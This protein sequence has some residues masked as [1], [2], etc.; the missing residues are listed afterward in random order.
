MRIFARK[1]KKIK[2]PWLFLATC[3]DVFIDPFAALAK[4]VFLKIRALAWTNP[5]L[6]SKVLKQAAL[7]QRSAKQ[8]TNG[9][10]SV[11]GFVA[12]SLGWE[13]NSDEPFYI[14]KPQQGTGF[15]I[16]EGSKS[17]LIE[18]L[19][20]A[21]RKFL[22]DHVPERQDYFGEL[23]SIDIFLTRFLHDSSFSTREDMEFL[24]PFLP[25]F[26]KDIQRV[27]AILQKLWSGQVYSAV[28]CKAAGLTESDCCFA[29]NEREDH[30]HLFKSCSFYGSTRPIG[31]F[32]D[33][34]WCT[35]IFPRSPIFDDWVREQNV[36]PVL[37]SQW[38]SVSTSEPVFIDGSAFANKWQPLR[39]AASAFWSNTHEWNSVLPGCDQTSQRAETY[40]LLYCVTFFGGDLTVY[41][42]CMN[43]LTG[44]HRL[45]SC[46]FSPSVLGQ[47]D[48]ADLWEIMGQVVARR[49]GVV[50]LRKVKAH[51]PNYD[52]QSQELTVGNTRADQLAKTCA[53]EKV[54]NQSWGISRYH[55]TSCCATDPLGHNN[56]LTNRTFYAR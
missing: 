14:S 51:V 33:S 20:H 23:D 55:C 41:T 46:N 45:V 32:H 2:S 22:L 42:D 4:H 13:L 30:L 50:T 17:F 8:T 12:R 3:C 28:R 56:D 47:L 29:C 9:I 18:E 6:A 39:T 52:H 16:K 34:T 27:R 36:L 5:D 31:D 19:D 10:A 49:P 43:V 21:C 53:K 48:N 1:F 37:P 38:F 24:Q 25:D 54:T 40:A 7:S 26:P 11:L 35:G 44:F 15:N